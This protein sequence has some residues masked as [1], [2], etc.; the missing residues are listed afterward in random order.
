MQHNLIINGVAYNNVKEISV[1]LNGGGNGVYIP[2]QK[3]KLKDINF[4]DYDGSLVESWTL[5]ELNNASTL[6]DNPVQ[7]GLTAQGWN[8]TLA[9]LKSYAIPMNI[10]QMYVTSDETTKLYITVKPTSLT[11]NICWKQTVTNGVSIKW[12]DGTSA[13]TITGTGYKS[14]THTYSSGN[15]YVIKF[16]VNTGCVLEFGVGDSSGNIIGNIGNSDANI[17]YRTMINKVELG[18]RTQIGIGAFQSL[19][20]LKTISIP[21]HITGIQDWSF[22]DSINLQYIT[23]PGGCTLGKG[24]FEYGGLVNISLAKNVSLYERCFSIARRLEG[25]TI[26]PTNTSIPLSCFSECASLARV[27]IPASVTSIASLSFNRCTNVA[28]YHIRKTNT[29]IVTLSNT[30]AFTKYD[31]SFKIYVPN[32]LLA[33]YKAGTNW[34]TY[35]SYIVGE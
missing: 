31:S 29:P 33:T 17:H 2:K 9:D 16:T 10:G 19:P 11:I 26:P 5:T 35:A 21:N 20:R 13:E 34:S 18:A 23:V 8:W 25:I 7:D 14:K 12:G 15:D 32:A 6:P 3:P 28:E 27:D 1:P 22:W 4:F 24:C 30:D